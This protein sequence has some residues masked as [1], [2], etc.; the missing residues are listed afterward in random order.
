MKLQACAVV[1]ATCVVA[2]FALTS[3]PTGNAFAQESASTPA[4]NAFAASATSATSAKQRAAERATKRAQ[5]KA[6]RKARRAKKNAE[7]QGIEKN[8]ARNGNQ[9]AV[10]PQSVFSGQ[11]KNGA[12]A[13]AAAPASA[14]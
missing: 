8:D 10:A 1:R 2:M 12:A 11:Y 4:A 5:R 3:A 14:P 6:E 13:S 9:G 7:L